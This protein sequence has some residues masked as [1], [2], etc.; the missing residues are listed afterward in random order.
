ML[1][2]CRVDVDGDIKSMSWCI[3]FGEGG[4]D[5]GFVKCIEER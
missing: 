3:G 4:V 1:K 5:E 2:P